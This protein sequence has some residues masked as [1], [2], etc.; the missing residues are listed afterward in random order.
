[1]SIDPFHWPLYFTL[2]LNP[3][4]PIADV[5]PQEVECPD[6]DVNDVAFM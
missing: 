1:M 4:V 3:P 5:K 6:S 2:Q